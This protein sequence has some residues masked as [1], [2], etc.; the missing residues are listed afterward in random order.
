MSA[1]MS[2]FWSVGDLLRRDELGRAQH[3]AG[4]GQML[5]AVV[6]QGR[7]AEPQLGRALLADHLGQAEVE[8]L[9]QRPAPVVGEHQVAGLD[10]AV[11]HPL[12]VRVLQP[13]RRLVDEIAGVADRN[14][15]PGPDQAAEVQPRGV[16]HG[17]DE[18]AAAADG[19]VGADDVGV[20]EPGDGPD[21]PQ[22]ALGH[23]GIGGDLRAD[24][25]ED[26]LAVHDAVVGQVDDPHAALP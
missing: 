4:A 2:A 26:L 9:D 25:L 1:R 18:A 13:Q 19:G 15:P 10:V 7:Q 11:D 24:D 14:R 22:E 12:L 5:T 6:R 21:L 16:L 3:A 17:E 8:Y 23:L 20:A